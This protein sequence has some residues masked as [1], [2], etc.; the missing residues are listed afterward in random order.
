MRL[1]KFRSIENF[2]FALDILRSHR[3]YCADWRALNDPMEGFFA[4]WTTPGSEK[5]LNAAAEGLSVQKRGKRICSL[6]ATFDSHLLWAHYASG[7]KGLAIEVEIPDDDPLVHKV[8]YRPDRFFSISPDD[9]KNTK[10]SDRVLT[11]KHEDWTYEQEVRI[12]TMNEWYPLSQPIRR[13]I[14]GFRMPTIE[15]EKLR[16]ICAAEGIIV[17]TTGI[18]DE[19]IDADLFESPLSPSSA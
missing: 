2:D 16:T 19:G 6:S 7:F 5:H 14:A 3:L 12:L 8:D 13:V 4:Y 9:F 17:C 15:F 10:L 1:F 11:S 18:G